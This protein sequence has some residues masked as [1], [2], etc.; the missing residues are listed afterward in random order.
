MATSMQSQLFFVFQL[1][2][3]LLV[4]GLVAR[5]YI[6]PALKRL[7]IVQALTP[8][9]L[10]HA[11]RYIGLSFLTPSVIDPNTPSRFTIPAAAGDVLTMALA[12]AALWA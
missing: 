9:L 7:P 2:M 1:L 5:W 3:S 12:L 10:F 11:T 8:L 6:G 4:Y